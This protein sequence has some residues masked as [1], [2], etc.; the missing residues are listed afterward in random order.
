MIIVYD[1]TLVLY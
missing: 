1:D